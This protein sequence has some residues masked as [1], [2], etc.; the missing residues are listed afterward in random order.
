MLLQSTLLLVDV[1]IE[2]CFSLCPAGVPTVQSQTSLLLTS[3]HGNAGALS[4][5]CLK[6]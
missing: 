3:L 6:C 2:L 4:I 5:A 1:P